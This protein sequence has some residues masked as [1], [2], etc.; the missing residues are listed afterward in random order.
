[1][2]KGQLIRRGRSWLLRY[3]KDENQSGSTVRKRVCEKI[4]PFNDRYRTEKSVRPLVDQILGPQNEGRV[5][6]GSQTLQQFIELNY[7]PHVRAHKKPST[8]KGYTD[9]FE[10][11]VSKHVAGLRV[12]EFRT[13]DGQRLLDKIASETKLSHRSLIHIKSFLSGVF[14]FAK[15][16]GALDGSNPMQGTSVPKGQPSKPTYAYSLT[17][18]E[19]TCRV[20]EAA[21][22]KTLR[23]AVI[24]AAYTG[25]TVSEIRGLRWTD[26]EENLIS[27]KNS[28]WKGHEVEP[29]TLARSAPVP[30]LPNV[31]EELQEHRK[32]NPGTKYVF[33]GPRGTPLDLSTAGAK[34]IRKALQN[35]GSEAPWMGWHPYRR[36]V[37]TTLHAKGVQDKVIQAILRHSSVAVTQSSYIKTLPESSVEAMQKLKMGSKVGQQ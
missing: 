10:D 5:S 18:V 13:V 35:A 6:S 17:E 22:E 2:Q 24:V 8:Q 9:I 28:F 4:A 25:L 14:S 12:Q 32:R 16:T 7:L 37:A 19:E 36:G 20:L 11:H 21:N 30:L 3:W 27:V 34:R 31:A 26:V 33:E 23:A 29:K 15:R 1:M